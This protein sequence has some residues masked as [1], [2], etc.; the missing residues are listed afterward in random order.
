[1]DIIWCVRY[2]KNYSHVRCCRRTHECNKEHVATATTNYVVHDDKESS[3][4]HYNTTCLAMW[5]VTLFTMTLTVTYNTLHVGVVMDR[6]L[7]IFFFIK[8]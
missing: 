1:M 7:N 3:S 8:W 6:D 2:N 4:C 5:C